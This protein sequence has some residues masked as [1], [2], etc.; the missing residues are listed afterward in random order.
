MADYRFRLRAD[1]R[2]ERLDLPFQL[3]DLRAQIVGLRHRPALAAGRQ[4]PI[5]TPPVQPD[6]L[7]LVERADQQAYPDRQELDLRERDLDVAGD[8]E[9]LVEHPIE[10]VDETCSAMIRRKLERHALRL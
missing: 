9:A 8:H 3:T 10:N 7:R 6:L 1:R 5:V 2:R 4:V